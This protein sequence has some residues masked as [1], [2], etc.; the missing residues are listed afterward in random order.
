MMGDRPPTTGC[1]AAD[2]GERE[3]TATQ[4]VPGGP[5]GTPRGRLLLMQ[6]RYEQRTFWRNP[7]A[8]FFT[9]A[10]PIVM[11]AIFTTLNSGDTRAGGR[12]FGAYFVPGML[13]FG[14][15]NS[16][17][18]Y[19]ATK[20]VTRRDTG[21][22]KRIRSTPLPLTVLLSAMI[23]NALLVTVM[24]TTLVLAVGR[25]LYQVALPNRW[26]LTAAVLL[27]GAVAFAA[28]GLALATVISSADG[29]DP[30]VFGTVL[31]LLF[32]SG[33][34]DDVPDGTAL[35]QIAR[36]FPVHHLLQ[37]ALATSGPI[38]TSVTRHLAV[39]AA[40]GAVGAL[41]AHKRFRWEA[42]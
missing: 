35:D 31:P 4:A 33:V 10:L 39:V 12:S 23:I 17:Y 42:R 38:T 36:L 11:L 32:I 15:I 8:V 26:G 25:L 9:F 6:L 37:S 2:R 30:V 7:G 21:L 22:L 41:I 40:W 29:A 18:G 24:I 13:T 19:L 28:L 16:T 3:S 34:F 20:I 1:S 14:L 27:I 5:P